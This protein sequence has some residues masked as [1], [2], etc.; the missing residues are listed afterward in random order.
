MIL[1]EMGQVYEYGAQ[2]FEVG[3]IISVSVENERQYGY[4]MEMNVGNESCPIAMRDF[5]GEDFRSLPLECLTPLETESPAA[6]GQM[7]VLCRFSGGLDER[8]T[9][10]L[11]ISA[12]KSV[13]LHLMLEDT[14][15]TQE[16]TQ[17]FFN[18]ACAD[19]ESDSLCFI[20]DNG[21]LEDPDYLN[22][23]LEPVQVY[24]TVEGGTTV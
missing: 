9:K 1:D 6:K 4:I 23:N 13:L 17:T 11:G 12:S 8:Q 22:Y 14:A 2:T 15:A 7:Y 21:N 24:S 18:S 16:G 20:Y 10:V 19:E 3:G 5:G